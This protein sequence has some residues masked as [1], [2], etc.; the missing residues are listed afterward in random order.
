MEF[1]P[2][3]VNYKKDAYV[4]VEGKS[5]DHF[6]IIH[7]GKVRVSREAKVEGEA[8]DILG[9]G[10]FFGVIATMSSHSHVDAAQALSDVSLITV[11]QKQYVGLIQK[12]PAAAMKIITMA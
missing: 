7:S 5:A 9:P 12:S 3:F 10:D 2:G 4:F 6:Y 8:D 11:P 1:Q